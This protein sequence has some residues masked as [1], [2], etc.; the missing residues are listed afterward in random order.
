MPSIDVDVFLRKRYYI[1]VLADQQ[2]T[3]ASENQDNANHLENSKLFCY[4]TTSWFE[5]AKATS[6][7]VQRVQ[8]PSH[9]GLACPP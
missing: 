6:A 7:T 4:F 1:P 5:V 9:Q 3:V 2:R 8:A